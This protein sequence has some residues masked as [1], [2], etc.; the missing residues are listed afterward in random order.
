MHTHMV[1]I[2]ALTQLFKIGLPFNN[3]VLQKLASPCSSHNFFL[4]CVFFRPICCLPSF[5]PPKKTKKKK[6]QRQDKPQVSTEAKKIQSGTKKSVQSVGSN[7]K[8]SK[9]IENSEHTGWQ[10]YLDRGLR[11][12]NITP[13]VKFS[14]L[15]LCQFTQESQVSNIDH[16]NPPI[17]IFSFLPRFLFFWLAHMNTEYRK[18]LFSQKFLDQ[19]PPQNWPK[20]LFSRIVFFATLWIFFMLVDTSRFLFSN[21]F[22]EKASLS[23]HQAIVADLFLSGIGAFL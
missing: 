6:I 1:Y 21:C 22:L 23:F 16:I 19:F 18:N 9:P 11:K 5:F 12:K 3:N 4:S 10:K 2:S 13:L 15:D 7:A 17:P 8:I 20:M 14:L